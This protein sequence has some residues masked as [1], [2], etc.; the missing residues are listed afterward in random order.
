MPIVDHT[1]RPVHDPLRGDRSWPIRPLV[2]DAA[3]VATDLRDALAGHDAEGALRD[4]EKIA[5]TGVTTIA[6]GTRVGHDGDLRALLSS[7]SLPRDVTLVVDTV[8]DADAITRTI[9]ALADTRGAI[10][11]LHHGDADDADTTLVRAAAEHC[12]AQADAHPGAV[13]G[14]HYAPAG[15]P[16]LRWETLVAHCDALIDALQPSPE[17]PLAMVLSVDADAIYPPHFADMVESVSRHLAGHGHVA[18][19]VDV[20]GPAAR[21]LVATQLAVYAGAT[22]VYGSALGMP[23]GAPLP[24]VAANLGVRSSVGATAPRTPDAH[25]DVVALLHD[26]GINPPQQMEA[27]IRAAAAAAEDGGP[28]TPAEGWELFRRTFIDH[29]GPS[30]VSAGLDSRA[31]IDTVSARLLVDG[32]DRKTR[33]HGGGPVEAFVTG[34]DQ[35]VGR[36]L[37]VDEFA[38]HSLGHGSDAR[39]ITYVRVDDGN[40]AAWG[41]GVDTSVLRSAFRAVLAAVARREG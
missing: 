20:D 40:V 34:L 6:L 16:G 39:A 1:D 17:R 4:V 11:H 32:T 18:V 33:G 13:R 38:Q 23:T 10:L 8:C 36:H 27:E 24:T 41:A 19:A 25:A 2:T 29:D 26:H 21:A 7:P 31:G 35:L 12:R 22:H 14:V 28:R 3:W 9:T 15:L 5:A 30:L 37:R